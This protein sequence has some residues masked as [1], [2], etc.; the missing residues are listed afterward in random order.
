[1]QDVSKAYKESMKKPLRGRGYIKAYI[2]VI[3]SDAQEAASVEAPENAFTYFSDTLKPFTGEKV[4]KPYATGEQDFTHVDGSMYFLPER[5]DEIPYYNGLVTEELPGA[6]CISFGDCTGLDIKGLTIDFGECYPIDFTVENDSGIKSYKGNTQAVW[7]T[8]DVFWG[9]SFFRITPSKMVNGMGRLRIGRFICGIA[10]TFSNKE[11]KS[12][13]F[14]DF[15]SPVSEDLPSQDMTLVVENNGLYYSADNPESAL[16]FMEMGQE[17]QV[18][19]GYGLEEGTIE[20]LPANTAYLKSWTADDKQAK[21]TATDRFDN[22]SGTYYRGIFRPQ[23]ISLY[24]LAVDVLQDAGFTDERDYF[25]DPYL[26]QVMIYNPV[27]V[28]SHADALKLIANAGRCVLYQDRKCRIHMQSSF[29]P[30]MTAQALDRTVY[31]SLKNILKDTPKEAYAMGS[32][33]FSVADGSVRF[34]PESGGEYLENGYVSGSIADVN[35]DF[36]VPPVVVIMLEAAFTCYGLCIRFRNV[37]PR[38]FTI[39]TWYEGEQVGEYPVQD[40][41]LTYVTN[42]MFALFDRMDIVFT[43]GAPHTRITVDS[44]LLGDVT[45]YL[46][47]YNY[48][49]QGTPAGTRQGKVQAVKV[50]RS[51]YRESDER[52]ELASEEVVIS[53]EAAEYTVYF[54][55][56]SYDLEAGIAENSSVTCEITECSCFQAKLHFSGMVKETVVKYTITGREYVVDNNFI[57]VQHNPNGEII[58][59]KNPLISTAEQARDLEEWLASY[60]L[61]DVDYKIS[62]RG[63]PRT[64]ANDLFYLELKNRETPLIRV[65]QNEL[66]FSG[67][68]SGSMKGRKAVLR[69]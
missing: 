33:D 65:Y 45:D 27:P 67:A 8:E 22:M 30:D 66:K 57:S 56:A 21:F 32:R 10:N 47:T 39:K 64:D 1:M 28:V 31:S 34:I 11:V 63:D 52:K 6:I 44:I 53:P 69:R 46:L 37:A 55:N 60:F 62:C 26:K 16:A 35:G 58:E 14:K 51:I 13:S 50:R 38:N 3:N 48:D 20:W 43:R 7:R 68:W 41:D 2:G 25:V 40:P 15:V 5:G 4:D 36:S 42:E 23:G 49:L 17:I 24:D 29:I 54:N 61:G 19:F 18:S 59:W 12:Y 9:T